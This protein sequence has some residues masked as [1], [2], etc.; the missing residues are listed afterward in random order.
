MKLHVSEGKGQYTIQQYHHDS[1]IVNAKDYHHSLIVMPTYLS[2]W[3][4]NQ[5]EQLTASHIEWFKTLQPELVLLG[6][7][8]QLR[9]PEQQLLLP[10][11]EQHIGVEV[12][13]TQAACRTYS[14]LM[15]EDRNVL[16]A[17]LL[18]TNIT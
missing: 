7:G 6:T 5:F 15:A 11:W 4:I 13:D 9:F 2:I 3:D 1:I 17:L 12:M 14:I 8:R 16:A 10:L 18:E